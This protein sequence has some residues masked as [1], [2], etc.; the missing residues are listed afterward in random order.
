MLDLKHLL[1]FKEVAER[2]S[3]SGAAEALSYS[4]PAVSQQIAALER[5]AGAKLVDRT[6]RGIRLTD[7][8]RVLLGHAEAILKRLAA[9]TAELEAINGLR[10][11]TVRLASFPTGGASLIPPATAVFHDR[12]PGVELTL[13][14][15]EAPEARELLRAGDVDLALLLESGFE[16]DAQNGRLERIHLLD[17][18]MYVALPADHP[19]A[20]RRKVRLASLRDETWMQGSHTANSCPDAA[21]FLRACHAAGFEPRVALENDD[22][23]AIQ[24]FVAAGVGVS[25]IPQL[26]LQSV[27]DDIAIRPL[28]APRVARRVV[29]AT[30]A[31]A[32]RSRAT[33]AMLEILQEVSAD[34]LRERPAPFAAVG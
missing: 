34:Y 28:A 32:Y 16:P 3:F 12:H 22:Y 26:A 27:R 25:L 6:P 9:T 31:N 11:G 23:A 29:A 30:A 10:A 4:Q 15:A 2:G 21:I 17:D 18:P 8:G 13:S 19:L 24:G 33:A 1:V 20:S 7:A 5:S 14:M